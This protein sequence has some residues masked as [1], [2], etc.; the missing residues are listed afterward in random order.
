[1][2]SGAKKSTLVSW[3]KIRLTAFD[4]RQCRQW[5][6]KNFEAFQDHCAWEEREGPRIFCRMKKVLIRL[7]WPSSIL[8]LSVVACLTWLNW[9][10]LRTKEKKEEGRSI[11]WCHQEISYSHSCYHES[12]RV[13]ILTPFSSSHREATYSKS[14]YLPVAVRQ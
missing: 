4:V 7:W 12:T 14:F 3:I 2:H 5:L 10:K 11:C 9:P 8:L 1:M 6:W 13:T